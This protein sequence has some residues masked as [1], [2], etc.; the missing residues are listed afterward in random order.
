MILSHGNLQ[1]KLYLRYHEV[2]PGKNVR[3]MVRAAPDSTVFLL[4]RKKRLAGDD[5]HDI[6]MNDVKPPIHY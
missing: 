3:L 2:E 6:T 5:G 1:V 4:G